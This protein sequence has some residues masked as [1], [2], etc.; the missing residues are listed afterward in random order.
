MGA[1]GAKSFQVPYETAWQL[2]MLYVLDK[3]ESDMELVCIFEKIAHTH[4]RKLFG[5]WRE[6]A[7]SVLKPKADL[8]YI[9]GSLCAY[10]FLFSAVIIL[11]LQTIEKLTL[12]R[13]GKP[14]DG[15]T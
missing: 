14:T 13:R 3:I 6:C 11:F 12:R 8:C 5:K 4:R 10:H 1:H 15:G 2:Q 9:S 7:F